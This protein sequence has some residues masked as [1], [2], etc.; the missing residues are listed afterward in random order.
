[1]SVDKF[2][3]NHYT[4]DSRPHDCPACCIAELRA[5]VDQLDKE[6]RAWQE[7][8]HALKD[9]YEPHMGFEITPSFGD[10]SDLEQRVD[11]MAEKRKKAFMEK[12]SKRK[13]VPESYDKIMDE[14]LKMLGER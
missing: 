8:C 9:K 2:H 13:I 10:H 3:H 7:R 11:D 1:M 12:E 6:A 5:R 4:R 14:I